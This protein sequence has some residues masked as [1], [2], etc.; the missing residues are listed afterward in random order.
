MCIYVKHPQAIFLQ[1]WLLG[2]LLT[3]G[4]TWLIVHHVRQSFSGACAFASEANHV[5][6]A[7]QLRIRGFDRS[8]DLLLSRILA[9]A[10]AHVLWCGTRAPSCLI[11]WIQEELGHSWRVSIVQMAR[12]NRAR[13]K[14]LCASAD[15][16]GGLG[17]SAVSATRAPEDMRA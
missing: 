10:R 14:K 9:Q 6:L 5:A 16:F 8:F 11:E 2:L 15:F 3:A 13:A 17:T 7:S 12:F 4:A 1:P